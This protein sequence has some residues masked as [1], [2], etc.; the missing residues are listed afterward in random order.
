MA[1]VL[2]ADTANFV[3]PESPFVPSPRHFLRQLDLGTL[4][5]FVL[6]CETGSIARAAERGQIAAS[7]LSRRV[8]ELEA[9]IG[10]P[11][12][13]RH[14]R[15]VRPT[16]LGDQLRQHALTILLNVEQLRSDLSE[17]AGGVRG[18]VRLSASASAVEQFLPGDMAR[19]ARTHPDIRIDL[20]QR[21]SRSVAQ[22]VIEGEADL[23]ICGACEPGL[24]LSARPY[25]T[26]RLVLVMP[27]GHALGV[28]SHVAYAESLDF[29]QVGMRG[30]STVQIHL[31]RVAREARRAL[32]QRVE[33]DS[34]SA[35]CRM[36]ECG[37]GIGVMAEGAFQALGERHLHAAE[38]TDAWAVSALN[39][40]AVDFAALSGPAMRFVE[41]LLAPEAVADT[42]LQ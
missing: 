40:Y 11:L 31:N 28:R 37:M 26:E 30:S 10:H 25:R 19:F 6:I 21:S 17:F 39:L 15:G 29:E 24:P 33:V 4:E 32:R 41:G 12:L 34:L 16:F 7:A 23:G 18:R 35:M 1:P 42:K 9:V 2:P 27:Q 8:A 14:A 3:K 38:L 20:R 5:L 13:A 36:I 22:D